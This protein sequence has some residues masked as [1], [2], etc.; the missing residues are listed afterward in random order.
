MEEKMI[1]M[2]ETAFDKVVSICTH[3]GQLLVA[4]KYAQELKPMTKLLYLLNHGEVL[5]QSI[6]EGYEEGFKKVFATIKEDQKYIED[7]SNIKL[8]I[9]DTFEEFERL[10][11]E[12]KIQGVNHER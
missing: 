10:A 6:I 1:S 5:P 11:Q 9:S 2:S 12:I 7:N 4:I 3:V 8:D